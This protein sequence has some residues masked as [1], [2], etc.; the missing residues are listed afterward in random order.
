MDDFGISQIL[1]NLATE[2]V[3]KLVNYLKDEMGVPEEVGLHQITKEDLIDS[4]LLKRKG[5]ELL[6]ERWQNGK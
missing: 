3:V 5:A 2:K 1:P 4:E 6:I